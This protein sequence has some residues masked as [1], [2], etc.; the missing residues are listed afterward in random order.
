MTFIRGQPEVYNNIPGT[1]D[2]ENK[3]YRPSSALSTASVEAW[4]RESP[5]ATPSHQ[6]KRLGSGKVSPS[7]ALNVHRAVCKQN[8]ASR[9]IDNDT[10]SDSSIPSTPDELEIHRKPA[11]S[12]T[13]NVAKALMEYEDASTYRKRPH[14]RDE[15][16]RQSSDSKLLDVSS[17]GRGSPFVRPK[18]YKRTTWATNSKSDVL[19]V[20]HYLWC[21]S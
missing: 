8:S 15:M 10:D 5:V 16:K 13:F 2:I 7:P 17:N 4:G 21:I 11:P 19:I 3:T 20:Y 14:S 1:P 18:L 9:L 12:M 6:K